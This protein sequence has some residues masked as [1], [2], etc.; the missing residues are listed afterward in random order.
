M[1]VAAVKKLLTY[2]HRFRDSASYRL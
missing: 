1:A 2:S